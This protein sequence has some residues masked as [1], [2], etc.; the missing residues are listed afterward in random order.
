MPPGIT[1]AVPPGPPG[2]SPFSPPPL[3]PPAPPPTTVVPSRL[4]GSE[5]IPHPGA[6][7]VILDAVVQDLGFEL[8][9]SEGRSEKRRL[10]IHR[11][12]AP[13]PAHISVRSYTYIHVKPN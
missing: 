13:P 11:L 12:R 10:Y 7:S 9:L 6:V 8:G 1:A 4:C 2:P 5:R 3:R